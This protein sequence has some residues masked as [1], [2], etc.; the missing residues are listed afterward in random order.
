MGWKRRFK[1]RG[2]AWSK[3]R[4]SETLCFKTASLRKRVAVL[5]SLA[6][7]GRQAAK[8]TALTSKAMYDSSEKRVYLVNQ[9]SSLAVLGQL[10]VPL[11]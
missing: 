7:V 10:R 2:Q 3:Q 5:T 4:K 6:V 9:F 11:A 1:S 8:V